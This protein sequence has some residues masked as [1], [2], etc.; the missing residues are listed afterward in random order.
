[1]C[2]SWETMQVVS[3]SNIV[4]GEQLGEIGIDGGNYSNGCRENNHI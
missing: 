3:P 1:M 2:I 4:L